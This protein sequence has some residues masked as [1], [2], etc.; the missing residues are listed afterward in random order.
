MGPRFVL[1]THAG[2]GDEIYIHANAFTLF[3]GLTG[4]GNTKICCNLPAKAE[5][6][7]KKKKTVNV[8]LNSASQGGC[9]QCWI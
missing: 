3:H 9:K 1:C 8:D 2:V 4:S 7:K 5:K 6:K